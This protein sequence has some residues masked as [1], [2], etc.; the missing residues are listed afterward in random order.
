MLLLRLHK[1]ENTFKNEEIFHPNSLINLV[2][3]TAKIIIQKIDCEF[4]KAANWYQYTVFKSIT[5]REIL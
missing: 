2:T 4:L 3:V 5:L 1:T